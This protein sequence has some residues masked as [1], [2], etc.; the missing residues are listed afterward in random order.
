MDR[1]LLGRDSASREGEGEDGIPGKRNG[2]S[3][4]AEVGEHSPSLGNVSSLPGLHLKDLT[5]EG[6]ESSLEWRLVAR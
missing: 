5:H 3:K 2:K 1:G 6:W 4:G